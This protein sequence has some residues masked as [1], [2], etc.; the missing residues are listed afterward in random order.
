V[1]LGPLD[2]FQAIVTLTLTESPY[3]SSASTLRRV[4]ALQC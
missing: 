4:S 2:G 3:F 1:A